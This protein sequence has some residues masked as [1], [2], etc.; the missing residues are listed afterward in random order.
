MPVNTDLNPAQPNDKES[1][2]VR[3]SRETAQVF[4]AARWYG[5]YP[6]VVRDIVDPKNMGRVKVL[7]TWAPD[8]G[9]MTGIQKAQQ[10]EAWAR[11]ATLMA[12]KDRG[13]WFMPDINDEVLISF[14]G[15]DPAFPFVVGALWNG[16][17]IPPEFMDSAGANNVKVLKTKSGTQIRFDDESGQE[18]IELRTPGGRT[19]RLSDDGDGSIQMAANGNKITIGQFEIVIQAGGKVSVNG[20]SLEVNAANVVVNSAMSTFNGTVKCKSLLTESI[21][22]NSYTPGVGNLW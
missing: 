19:V 13:S 9:G 17:D 10:Y 7:L 2:A 6:A 3:E 1:L 5:V 15:G 22:A 18:E 4:P 11:V 8:T 16:K 12:G 14:Q 21:K 20:S